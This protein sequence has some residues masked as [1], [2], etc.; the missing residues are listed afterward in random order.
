MPSMRLARWDGCRWRT[1]RQRHSEKGEW[2][3]ATELSDDEEEEDREAGGG[4][5][6][7]EMSCSE[8]EDMDGGMV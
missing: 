1:R 6:L 2:V 7:E 8:D 5:G 3:A 4:A